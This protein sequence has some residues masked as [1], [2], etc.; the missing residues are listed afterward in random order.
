MSA[1]YRVALEAELEVE[2]IDP[3][4]EERRIFQMMSSSDAADTGEAGSSL[5]MCHGLGGD[6]AVMAAA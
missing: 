6:K 4:L 2:S 5:S 3:A 1:L